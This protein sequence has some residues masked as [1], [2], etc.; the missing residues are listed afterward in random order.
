VS[1]LLAGDERVR[2]SRSA[3]AHPL[4]VLELGASEPAPA[5]VPAV[6]PVLEPLLAVLAPPVPEV[7]APAEL[8][9]LEVS[10]AAVE[11]PSGDPHATAGAAED[12]DEGAAL[13][14]SP[15]DPPVVKAIV[16]VAVPVDVVAPAPCADAGF[17]AQ[18]LPAELPME[19]VPTV[20]AVEDRAIPSRLAAAA[21]IRAFSRRLAGVLEGAIGWAMAAGYRLMISAGAPAAWALPVEASWTPAA[22]DGPAFGLAATTCAL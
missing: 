1:I 13:D 21:G 11:D 5:A 18:P 17:V 6:P 16:P 2:W 9:L 15:A 7:L 19:D 8:L 20:A 4:V 14:C 12:D 3:A 22:A 10:E